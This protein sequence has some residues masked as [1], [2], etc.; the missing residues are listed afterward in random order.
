MD[1][2]VVLLSLSA[3]I[4]A[5]AIVYTQKINKRR[6]TVDVLLDQSKNEELNNSRKKLIELKKKNSITQYANDSFA[7]SPEREAIL[8][9]LST[10]EL[11]AVGVREGAFDIKLF[12]RMRYSTVLYDWNALHPFISEI[13]SQKGQKTAFQEFEWLAKRFIK[14]KLRQDKDY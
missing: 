11:V 1:A 2:K 14:R 10:Y 4:A 7:G 12:K 5:L 3:L 8:K 13:R 6:A 9:V